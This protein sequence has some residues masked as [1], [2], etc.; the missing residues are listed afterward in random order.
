MSDMDKSKLYVQSFIQDHLLIMEGCSYEERGFLYTLYIH[1]GAVGKT[2]NVNNT[3]E[4]AEFLGVEDDVVA[5]FISKRSMKRALAK[6]VEIFTLRWNEQQSYKAKISE[7]N[8]ANGKKSAEARSKSKEETTD[9]FDKPKKPKP[10]EIAFPHVDLTD[11]DS[12]KE[13]LRRFFNAYFPGNR[14]VT[15]EQIFDFLDLIC[16]ANPP[17]D[18]R[19]ALKAMWISCGDNPTKY[20]PAYA[21]WIEKKL[22]LAT[23]K[24]SYEK[25]RDASPTNIIELAKEPDPPMQV[26][27]DDDDERFN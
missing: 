27:E 17:F 24:R 19:L 23:D 2:P 6:L 9:D 14:K 12:D 20:A 25:L 11:V 22:Y 10:S 3:E 13:E 15:E 16:S 18:Y 8:S 21:K 7:I 1:C 5:Q 26:L 4:I